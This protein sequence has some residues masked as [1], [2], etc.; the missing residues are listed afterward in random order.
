MS[1]MQSLALIAIDKYAEHE[2]KTVERRGR[3]ATDVQPGRLSENGHDRRVAEQQPRL[4][5]WLKTT[6][7]TFLGEKIGSKRCK[8][9]QRE[10]SCKQGRTRKKDGAFSHYH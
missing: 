7:G 1:S 3:K 8:R 4:R 2:G 9:N 10:T 5:L 6:R